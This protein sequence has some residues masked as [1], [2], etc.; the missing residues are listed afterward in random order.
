[1]KDKNHM[2]MSMDAEKAFN[3][4]QHSFMITIFHKIGKEEVYLKII[5]IIYDKPTV[6]IMLNSKKLKAFPL[7]QEQDTDAH[8]CHFYLT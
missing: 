3:K 6:N 4:I 8:S 7:D 5:K 2:I 1:M